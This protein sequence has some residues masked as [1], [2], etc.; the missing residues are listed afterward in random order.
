[1]CCLLVVSVLCL[2]PPFSVSLWLLI[3]SS[4]SVYVMCVVVFPP[5]LFVFSICFCLFVGLFVLVDLCFHCFFC[6]CFVL[7]VVV[8]PRMI[9]ARMQLRLW[10]LLLL[11]LLLPQ[12]L[13]PPLPLL[14]CLFLFICE[15]CFSLCFNACVI[16]CLIYTWF[17]CCLCCS[18]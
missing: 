16:P 17:M 12:L 1:M 7:F 14:F 6:V 8:L 13:L 2:W 18:V 10:V 4:L 15:C 3:F 9:L 11:L 5:R